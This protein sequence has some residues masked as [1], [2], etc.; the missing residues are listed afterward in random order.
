MAIRPPI[1]K[2]NN[3]HPL[4]D[5]MAQIGAEPLRGAVGWAF[6][7]EYLPA[8]NAD[9]S[10]PFVIHNLYLALRHHVLKEED[11]SRFAKD[12]ESLA[13]AGVLELRIRINRETKRLGLGDAAG[14]GPGQEGPRPGEP[15][16]VQRHFRAHMQELKERQDDA[17][18]LK[19]PTQQ[20]VKPSAPVDKLTGARD[21]ALRVRQKMINAMRK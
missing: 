12:P 1:V 14:Q 4:N 21:L 8:F 17:G 2:K 15:T 19:L 6:K 20:E 5:Y 16:P 13:H 18:V 7:P 9:N 10:N 3:S 11:L